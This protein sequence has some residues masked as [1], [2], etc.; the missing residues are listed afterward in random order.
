E[1]P[2][3]IDRECLGVKRR[4]RR[5]QNRPSFRCNPAARPDRGDSPLRFAAWRTAHFEQSDSLFEQGAA[6]WRVAGMDHPYVAGGETIGE[7]RDRDTILG[8]SAEGFDARLRRHE[9]A[10]YEANLVTRFTHR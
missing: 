4:R 9:I 3:A 2:L 6:V 7:D 10:R 8:K 1:E 5:A